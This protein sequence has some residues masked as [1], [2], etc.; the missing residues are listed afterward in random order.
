M[1]EKRKAVVVGAGIGGLAMGIRLQALG[2]QTTIVEA[3]DG[4]GGRAAVRREGGFTFDMGPTVITVPAFIEELFAQQ[5]GHPGLSAPDFPLKQGGT[6]TSQYCRIVPVTPYYRIAFDDGTVFDYD[7]DEAGTRRRIAELA[8]ADL[9]GYDRFQRDAKAIFD[10]GF[11]ELGHT[12]FGDIRSMIRVAPDLL[13]L[14][15]LRTLFGFASKYFRTDKMRQI[16]SFET[17]L[18]GGSPLRVPSIYAMIHFVEKTWGVHYVMGGTGALVQGFVKK[19]EQLG[20]HVRYGSPVDRILVAAESGGPTT[21]RRTTRTTGVRLQ[22]GDALAADLV[23]SNADYVH[24]YRDLLAPS[25]RGVIESL[26][27]KTARQSMS[28]VVIYFGFRARPEDGARLRHHNVI[29]GPRYEELLR[30]IFDRKTL[31][32]DFSQYLHLP[33]LTDPSLAPP[34]MHAAY[35][36]VP[37]PNNASGIDWSTHGPRLV[38]K[39]LGFL[40]AR[41]YI[42]DLAARLVTKSFVT[43]EYFQKTLRSDLGNAFGLEPVLTQS[44]A[45]RPHNRATAIDGLYLVGANA[46][47]GAGTPSVMMSAKMTARLVAA[48]F[49]IG[50]S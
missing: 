46:Q 41:G 33:T 48:D 20:G 37:V 3:L 40:E 44:A 49:G 42:P 11:L 45:F 1:S 50:E 24:T 43:P 7:G 29:L 25:E 4:P 36:L 6:A 18:I 26:R 12:H 2:F 13:R 8:P 32:D 23:V 27:M 28:L 10:R 21:R 17:L 34:G 22:S 16:F 38:D 31:A 5:V 14:D 9:D 30:D 39:V 35:T 47:P 19:F 15:A